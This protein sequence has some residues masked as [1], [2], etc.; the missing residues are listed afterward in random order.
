MHSIMEIGRK[1]LHQWIDLEGSEP[2]PR[3]NVEEDEE[4]EGKECC[5]AKEGQLARRSIGEARLIRG[6][7]PVLLQALAEWTSSL[8]MGKDIFARFEQDDAAT[9]SA[10]VNVV[11]CLSQQAKKKNPLSVQPLWPRQPTL[12]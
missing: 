11:W 7:D 6:I 3:V 10:M 5:A 2:A 8:E 4:K 9:R 12:L 1:D